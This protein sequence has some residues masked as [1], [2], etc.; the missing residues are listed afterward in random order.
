MAISLYD[1]PS[2]T[3]NVKIDRCIGDSVSTAA[4]SR[5]SFSIATVPSSASDALTRST[6]PTIAKEI[7]RN[8]QQPGAEA[9]LAPKRIQRSERT[10][11]RILHDLLHLVALAEAR[12][13]T[14]DR[15]RVAF[16]Q[17]RGRTLFATPPPRDK[18]C[19]VRCEL[20]R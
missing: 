19:V 6:A 16:D 11:E 7:S 4:R 1:S 14:R 2:A 8:R 18:R 17:R 12:H 15:L 3:R 20:A 5:C 9:A 10:D 13:E